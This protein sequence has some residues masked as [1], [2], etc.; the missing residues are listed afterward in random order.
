MQ[1]WLRESFN[2]FSDEK[3]RQL[4]LR[5]DDVDGQTSIVRF[6]TPNNLM[7]VLNEDMRNI[8]NTISS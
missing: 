2:A 1:T 4:S 7:E 3:M 8:S 6:A 5:I